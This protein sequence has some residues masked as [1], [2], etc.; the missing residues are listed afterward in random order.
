MIAKVPPETV[1]NILSHLTISDIHSVQLASK[2]CNELVN[3]NET[4]VYHSA[5]VVH[6]FVASHN[7]KIDRLEELYPSEVFKGMKRTWKGLCQRMFQLDKNW[8]GEGQVYL[9]CFPKAGEKPAGI[10]VD[11]QRGFIINVTD[12]EGDDSGLI[13]VDKNDKVLW[14]QPWPFMKCAR[15]EYENG[16][17]IFSENDKQKPGYKEMLALG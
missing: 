5:A 7:I 10:K 17:L 3:S 12:L 13:V 6:G 15:M 9:T 1:T 14:N 11:E 2:S 4:T 16:Y 8:D